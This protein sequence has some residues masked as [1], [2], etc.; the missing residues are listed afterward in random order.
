M[1]VLTILSTLLFNQTPLRIGFFIPPITPH[2]KKILA[3]VKTIPPE[4]SISTQVD[5]LKHVCHRVHA[6]SGYHEGSEYIFVDERSLWYSQHAQWDKILPSILATGAYEKIH[7]DEGI[8]I[9][10]R[11]TPSTT[12]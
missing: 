3:L 8:K 1:L 11:R 7:D 12:E 2:Q 10:R 9:Y 5:I 4:A 6:Y